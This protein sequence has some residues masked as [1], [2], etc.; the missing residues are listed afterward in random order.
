VKPPS[1]SKVISTGICEANSKS[2]TANIIQAS[3]L[4]V[5]QEKPVF[6]NFTPRGKRQVFLNLFTIK[7]L[8]FEGC[9]GPDKEENLKDNQ[10]KLTTI[11]QRKPQSLNTMI[12]KKVTEE[13]SEGLDSILSDA[14][15]VD[16]K[17]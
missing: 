11:R 13:V 1:D 2:D 17:S 5:N 9:F 12:S 15:K 4:R 6:Q 14:L 7:C 3:H 8:F 16:L 10:L